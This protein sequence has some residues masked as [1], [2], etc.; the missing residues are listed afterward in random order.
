MSALL[1]NIRFIEIPSNF[2]Y[3]IS[4]AHMFPEADARRKFYWPVFPVTLPTLYPSEGRGA[5]LSVVQALL[6]SRNLFGP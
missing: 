3:I 4:L 2:S 1:M 5:F 6:F